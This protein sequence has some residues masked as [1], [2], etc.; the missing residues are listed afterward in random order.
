MRTTWKDRLKPWAD[1]L[2]ALELRWEKR[3]KKLSSGQLKKLEFD[4]RCPTASN[5]WWATFQSA[6]KLIGMIYAEGN[7]RTAK[8]RPKESR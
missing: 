6:Q 1:E 7:R 4:V 3:L 8:A 5:S 2:A